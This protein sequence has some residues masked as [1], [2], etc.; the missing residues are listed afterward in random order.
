M[1]GEDEWIEDAIQAKTLIAVTNRSYIRELYP[2]LYSAAFIPECT[3]GDGRLVRS[4]P[5]QT[6]A[7][8]AYRGEL[9]DIMAIHLVLL[10]VNQTSPVL[11]IT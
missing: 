2:D 3:N 11:D 8:N 4:L 7:A 10:N 6:I 5:E 9:L 1:T